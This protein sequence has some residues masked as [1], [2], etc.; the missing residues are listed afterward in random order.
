MTKKAL[1]LG[2]SGH[3]FYLPRKSPILV[4]LFLVFAGLSPCIAQESIQEL[5]QE[6]QTKEEPVG[7]PIPK[8]YQEDLGELEKP[9]EKPLWRGIVISAGSFPFSY[10][11]TNLAFDLV[12]YATQGFDPSYA[13]WPFRS[14]RSA[15]ISNG[16]NFLR[17]GVTLGLSAIIGLADFLAAP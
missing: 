8:T 7:S 16:E 11:Y 10:F 9:V 14:S 4:C 1:R 12:R 6:A 3:R 13:P 15:G 2:S 17:L 5:P